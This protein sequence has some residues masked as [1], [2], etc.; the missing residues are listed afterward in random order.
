[1][2]NKPTANKWLIATVIVMGLV[3]IGLVAWII[4]GGAK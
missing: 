4:V 1:M 2:E 3:I